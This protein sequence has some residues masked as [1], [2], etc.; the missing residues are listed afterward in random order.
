MEEAL[1][2][3]PGVGCLWAGL[4]GGGCPD[5][6][7]FLFITACVPSSH[8]K[9]SEA[10]P[11]A[12]LHH[13][14]PYTLHQTSAALL[15]HLA[16]TRGHL[17]LTLPLTNLPV[18]K[19]QSDSLPWKVEGTSRTEVMARLCVRPLHCQ[20]LMRLSEE[21]S[22]GPPMPLLSPLSQLILSVMY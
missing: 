14:P 17:Y 18:I 10:G 1:C 4:C 19:I 2:F 16:A 12:C 6:P 3:H 8:H 13:T 5:C 15:S 9:S 21:T 7:S 11:A 20:S 22:F